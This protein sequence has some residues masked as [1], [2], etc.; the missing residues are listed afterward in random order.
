[1]NKKKT[2]RDPEAV[3]FAQARDEMFSHVLRCGVIDAL[4]EHQKDWFDDTMLYLADRYEDLSEEE[5][6]QLR[7]SGRALLPAGSAEGRGR[8]KRRSV[9]SWSSHDAAPMHALCTGAFVLLT[10]PATP[11]GAGATGIRAPGARRRRHPPRRT[12]PTRDPGRLSSPSVRTT[13]PWSTGPPTTAIPPAPYSPAPL[14]RVGIEEEVRQQLA[15]P[16]GVAVAHARPERRRDPRAERRPE[17]AVGPGDG[18]RRIGRGRRCPGRRARRR[19]VPRP[20]RHARQ[21]AERGARSARGR[22]RDDMVGGATRPAARTLAQREPMRDPDV[23]RERVEHRAVLRDREI[24]GAARLGL[25][26]PVAARCGTPGG[27]PCSGA[28]PPPAAPRWPRSGTR[29]ASTRIFSR[30]DDHVG[31]ACSAAA[32]SSSVSI[33]PG[34]R[35]RC[36]RRSSSAARPARRPGRSSRSCQARVT[37]LVSAVIAQSPPPTRRSALGATR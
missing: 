29:A 32:A 13:Y 24:D 11:A 27:S 18:Q 23:R 33:G 21:A 28:A 2:Q 12:S 31:A 3:A 4:P 9:S 7:Q 25:V 14:R 10:R 1:M 37:R 17:R 22:R 20:R 35:S 15:A 34:R 6:A 30:I 16:R 36:R 5:L 8:R 19:A 26:E